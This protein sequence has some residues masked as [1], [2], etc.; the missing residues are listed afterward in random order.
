M[1]LH[2]IPIKYHAGHPHH[3]VVLLLLPVRMSKASCCS[4][5]CCCCCCCLQQS[6]YCCCGSTTQAAG[7][8]L[9]LLLLPGASRCHA[10]Q[11]PLQQVAGLL[12]PLLLWGWCCVMCQW[13]P[14]QAPRV[15]LGPHVRGAACGGLQQQSVK[16]WSTRAAGQQT[17]GSDSASQQ[18]H[19]P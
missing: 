18:Q 15:Q 19:K 1:H 3:N 4:C 10:A 12:L 7:G 6:Q 16:T 9:L 11:Q 17:S 13:D 8:R 2:N 5:C 14:V